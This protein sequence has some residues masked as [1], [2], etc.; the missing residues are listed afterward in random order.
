MKSK[1]KLFSFALYDSG[2]TVLGALIFSTLYPLYITQHIGVKT[3]SFVYGFAF[4]LS[5]LIALQLSKFADRKG[6]RKVFFVFFSLSVPFV[7][8]L[9][10]LSFENPR[11]NFLLYL[12]LAILHQQALVFYN[13]L[14]KSFDEKGFV[15]GFG[16]ALGY[17]ASAIALV[18]LAPQLSLPTAFVWTASIFFL[19]S[20]PSFL[21]LSEPKEKQEVIVKNLLKDK[22]FMLTMASMLLLME[23]AHTMIAMMGVYLRNVYGLEEREIYRTIGFSAIGGVLGGL[24]FGKLTDK[25]SAERL[26]PIGFLLWSLFIL[27]LYIT[28]KNLLLPL[29]FFA[30]LCLAH[31]WTTSRVLL[32]ER[33]ARGDV[34]VRFSF[35]SLS[36]RIASSLGLMFWSFFLLITEENYRLSALLMLIFPSIGAILYILSDRRFKVDRF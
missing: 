8:L 22:R 1:L 10:F 20:F 7:C 19:L 9:L 24:I 25:I 23:L 13:S 26:F 14:L 2:E 16:V 12:L 34:A 28:P 18:F 15:S 11:L 31:L 27:M 3:Y 21:A 30:G 5:F 32:I 35:Y 17:M 6:L 4:F 33:F 29:G 36:E